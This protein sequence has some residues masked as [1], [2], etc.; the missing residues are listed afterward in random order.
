MTHES[1]AQELPCNDCSI[2]K[3]VRSDY[4]LRPAPIGFLTTNLFHLIAHLWFPSTLFTNANATQ[5][6]L[7]MS[8]LTTNVLGLSPIHGPFN[9]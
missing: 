2:A 8:N 9:S 5:S 6:S 3:L 4:G 7:A 1:C